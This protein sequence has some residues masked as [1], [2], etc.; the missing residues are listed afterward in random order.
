M[1]AAIFDMDGTLLDSMHVWDKITSE[2]FKKYNLTYTS[3]LLE[4]FQEMT[5]QE[6]CMLIKER[7]ALSQSADEINSELNRMAADE[8]INR[9]PL[10]PYAKEYVTQLHKSGIK[11]AI[12]TS[13]YYDLCR[14]ALSR[15][16]IWDMFDAVAL[17]SE[18]GV[19]KA[20]P[21]VYLLAAE[22]LGVKPEECTVFE[23]IL[24]GTLGAKKAGM[25]VIAIYDESSENVSEQIRAAADG[26]IM[27]WSEITE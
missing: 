14:A 27:S 5:L 12:A 15:T 1:K 23:D 22:R 24:T 4:Q 16:G 26:Y 13:G 7:F 3:E 19:N 10:K 20:N 21:D 25:K 11:L 6:S 2:F 18:V 9:I 8:Y 17:S